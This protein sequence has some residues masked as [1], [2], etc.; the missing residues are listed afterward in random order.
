[1]LKIIRIRQYENLHIFLWL[2]KDTCWIMDWKPAGLFM[3]IPT[4][5]VAIHITWL[6]RNIRSDLFHNM[7]VCLWISG[8]SI[9]MLGE[10]FYDDGT[11]PIAVIFFLVGLLSVLY[12]YLME[13]PQQW[14]KEDKGLN[15]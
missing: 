5:F 13:E 11:R 3:I 1:M 15:P 4:I 6:R 14:K 12:Y 8:N 9:W 7:A 2:L 10:F